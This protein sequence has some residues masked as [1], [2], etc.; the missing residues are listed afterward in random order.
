MKFFL[1]NSNLETMLKQV[2][3]T[4]A[5]G[6]IQSKL[7]VSME[8]QWQYKVTRSDAYISLFNE[9]D[10]HWLEVLNRIMKKPVTPI[11]DL[12]RHSEKVDIQKTLNRFKFSEPDV[13]YI[14]GIIR[15]LTIEFDKSLNPAKIEN[16]AIKCGITSTCSLCTHGHMQYNFKSTTYKFVECKASANVDS[17]LFGLCSEFSRRGL[18]DGI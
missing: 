14:I 15:A 13:R 17:E 3:T 2:D 5:S 9:A 4:Q 6:K 10:L 18:D 8:D 16:L 1:A 7:T 11:E 12:W